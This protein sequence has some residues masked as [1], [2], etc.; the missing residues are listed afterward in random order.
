MGIFYYKPYPGNKIADELTASGYSFADSLEDWSDFDYVGDKGNEWISEKMYREIENFKFY[1][2]VAY[3][4]PTRTK[5]LFQ[6]LAKW[7]IENKVYQLPFEKKLME[8]LRPLPKM[9]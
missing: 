7:R 6:Q 5:F 8:W 4:K 1:Q 3:N 9:S 2:N